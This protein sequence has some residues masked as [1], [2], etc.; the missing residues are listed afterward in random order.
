MTFIHTG[1]N[2]QG[3]TD[4][5]E[6]KFLVAYFSHTGNTR[7]LAAQIQQALQCDIFEIVPEKP[8]PDDYDSCVYQSK[9]EIKANYKPALKTHIG[10]INDY[11]VIFVGSPCWW[12][13]IAPPVAAFLAEND[14]SGKTIAPF[15]T[16]EGSGMGVSMD[17]IKKLC[18]QAILLE[19]LPIRGSK[20]KNAGEEVS[21]WLKK[22]KLLK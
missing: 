9:K 7:Q 13:T 21:A 15:M 11:D 16:H 17:D 10:N 5:S 4:P 22:L 8:Y 19:P 1:C 6:K 14:F 18:P 20:V 2:S 3:K 12:H